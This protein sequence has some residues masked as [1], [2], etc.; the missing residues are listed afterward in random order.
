MILPEVLPTETQTDDLARAFD[1]Y[2][3]RRI[4]EHYCALQD[5]AREYEELMQQLDAQVRRTGA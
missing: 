1:I 4:W 2:Q 3:T 5:R